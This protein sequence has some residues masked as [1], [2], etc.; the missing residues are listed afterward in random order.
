MLHLTSTPPVLQNSKSDESPAAASGSSD[1]MTL[2]YATTREPR[3]EED[4]RSYDGTL[5]DGLRL[6]VATLHVDEESGKARVRELQTLPLLTGSWDRPTA[7][8]QSLSEKA[9]FRSG[10]DLDVLSHDTERFFADIDHALS[11]GHD[12]DVFIYVHGGMNGV[13]RTAAQAAQYCELTERD[14]VVVAFVWPTTDYFPNYR[15]DVSNARQS[16]PAFSRFIELLARHTH[17]Q[18]INILAH[19]AGARI[20]SSALASLGEAAKGAAREG[21]RDQLRLGEVY[22]AAAD[23][24]IKEF[25]RQLKH[26]ADLPLRVTLQANRDDH[27]LALLGMLPSGSRAGRLNLDELNT[28][29]LESLKH[30]ANGSRLDIV[31]VTSERGGNLTA[32]GHAFW[33]QRRWVSSDLLLEFM[34]HVPP[35]MRG[36]EPSD[37]DGLRRWVFPSDYEKRVAAALQRLSRL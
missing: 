23:I 10:A 36:L 1:R 28:P 4:A 26:Y 19:S 34:Y 32:R 5:G 35:E 37:S 17:A 9:V 20:V 6:G 25:V 2:L 22:Y 24:E 11:A 27:I 21:L 31:D 18:H 13:D 15:D 29:E 8:L 12:K 7:H 14:S 33:Y 3:G 30:W 16:V